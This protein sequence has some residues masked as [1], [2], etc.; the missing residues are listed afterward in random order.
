MASNS[1][2]FQKDDSGRDL[3]W[4]PQW[5][6][7][8]NCSSVQNLETLPGGLKYE[9]LILT[10]HNNFQRFMDMKNL[11]SRQVCWAQE[12]SKYHFWIDYQQDKA[13][14]TADALSQYPQRSAEEEKT[15]QAENTKI[16][17]QL[18]S[19]LAWV[20]GLSILRMSVP[21]MK[22][23]VLYPLYQILICEIVILPQLRQFWDFV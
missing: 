16:L 8:G 10:D 14:G 9:V 15:L 5:W 2:F 1:L 17:H 4:D 3:V 22:Q 19:L 7:A 20:F 23:Q 21:G 6:V 18:Q 13:N 12:L 11:S